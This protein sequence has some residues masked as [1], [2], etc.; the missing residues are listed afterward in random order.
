MVPH[1]R[2]YVSTSGLA[3][4]ADNM[5]HVLGY[6]VL[7]QLT[8]SPFWLGYA[9]FV[10]WLPFTLFS[11]YSG[12][13]AD[14]VSCRW[15]MQLAQ[16]IYM[17]VSF[18]WGLLV[19]TGSLQLWHMAVLL[20][21]HGMAGLIFTPSSMLVIYE[22]VG[23]EKLLSAVS[24]NASLRPVASTLGPA[25]GGFLLWSV[26]PGFG[27]LINVL[28]YVPF[29]IF[30]LVLP[31]GRTVEERKEKG[32]GFIVGGLTAV[33]QSPAIMA[34]M[35]VVAITALLIGNAV[36][37]FVPAFTERL[38]V[39]STGYSMLLSAHGIGALLGGLFLGWAGTTKLRPAMVTAGVLIWSTLLVAFSLS[40]IS[41]SPWR[42]FA[43]WAPRRSPLAP[44][45]R[46][47]FSPGPR[48]R[49]GA[50]SS[51]CTT[52]P[53]TGHAWSAGSCWVR[54]EPCWDLPSRSSFWQ[55]WLGES[56]SQRR[57]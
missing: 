6:W 5:E 15:L 38:G 28:F 53:P 11:L 51:E 57:S 56:L 46:A 47:S 8:G 43:W 21:I 23:R 34:V 48:S 2:Y 31:Y 17:L 22:M 41:P 36:H 54:W 16:V 19:L 4:I 33:R 32:W 49:S 40:R 12:S 26:G 13:L 10:H 30:L 18:S 24:L 50:A 44:R 29:S 14:R 3:M 1:F 37:A 39:A 20:V 42:F 45:L 35:G 7:W 55:G 25:I 9:V 27:F 52:L